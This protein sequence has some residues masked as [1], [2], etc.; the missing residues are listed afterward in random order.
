MNTEIIT[1]QAGELNLLWEQTEEKGKVFAE[2]TREFLSSAVELGH[3]LTAAKAAVIE[4]NGG[5]GSWWSW[6]AENCPAIDPKLAQSYMRV[7]R[8]F[9]LNEPLPQGVATLKQA[10]ALVAKS[11]EELLEKETEEQVSLF[12]DGAVFKP[13]WVGRLIDTFFNKASKLP[14]SSWDDDMKRD[15]R[16]RLSAMQQL[17]QRVGVEA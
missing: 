15:L 13:T 2:H 14:S 12:N 10:L 11:E 9:P 7:A 3:A 17:A 5:P 8:H 1:A 16:D 6:L 4:A